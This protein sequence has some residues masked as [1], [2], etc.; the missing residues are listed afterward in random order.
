MFQENTRVGPNKDQTYNYLA[1]GTQNAGHFTTVS[2]YTSCQFNQIIYNPE[3]AGFCLSFIILGNFSPKSSMIKKLAS[4]T[5]K[6]F[7]AFVMTVVVVCIVVGILHSW[8]AF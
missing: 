7:D 4:C 5:L 2:L 8:S 1:E 6:V 3:K